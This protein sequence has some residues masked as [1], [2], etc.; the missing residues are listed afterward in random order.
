MGEGGRGRTGK[1]GGSEGK[2]LQRGERSH[3]HTVRRNS[4]NLG[5]TAG[6][7]ARPVVK[8]VD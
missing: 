4:K 6:E 1:G 3:E 5:Y 2:K 8:R 7:V